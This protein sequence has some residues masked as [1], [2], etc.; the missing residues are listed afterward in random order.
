MRG[1]EV[2]TEHYGN[3]IYKTQLEAIKQFVSRLPTNDKEKF[4]KD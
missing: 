1:P 4:K 2:H 3:D